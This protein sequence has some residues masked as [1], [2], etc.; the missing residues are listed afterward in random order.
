MTESRRLIILG[1][2][3]SIGTATLEVVAYLAQQDDAPRYTVVGLAAGSNAALLAQ[4]AEQFGVHDVALADIHASSALP[5]SLRTITGPAAALELIDRVAQPGDMV[6]AAMVGVAGLAPVLAAIER[7]A[8]LRSPTRKR[9]LQRD[10]W[11][12][13]RSLAKA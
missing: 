9:W 6:M 5:A 8:T 7:G 10:R 2:T 3:G 1:S 11:S 13:R 12:K 4:Q